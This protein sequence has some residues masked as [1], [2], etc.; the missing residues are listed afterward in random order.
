L[1]TCCPPGPL[2]RENISSISASRRFFIQKTSFL[3]AKSFFAELILGG[4]SSRMAQISNT[5]AA[6]PLPD[7]TDPKTAR[8]TPLACTVETAAPPIRRRF[9]AEKWGM[10]DDAPPICPLALALTETP[11]HDAS[12]LNS[13]S[14]LHVCSPYWQLN[15]GAASSG[16]WLASLPRRLR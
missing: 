12:R 4:P 8:T 16:R 6:K 14:R 3:L 15:P 5:E 2:E 1:F 13:A 9:A 11:L 7:T 10:Q